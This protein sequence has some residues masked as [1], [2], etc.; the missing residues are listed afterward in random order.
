[1]DRVRKHVTF[2]N[3]ASLMALVFAMG[4]TGYAISSLPKN[5]VGT[6]QLKQGAVVSSK[7]K[8]GSLKK[9]DFKAGQLP[10]GPQGIQGPKGDQGLPGNDGRPGADGKPGT[11]GSITVQETTATADLAD[12]TKQSYD[13]VCPTGQFAL[14][15]GGRGDDV[16]SE[17]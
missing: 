17:E 9:I 14:G 16:N 4:G 13:V 3:V 10:A 15:G 1:M 2:A 6:R 12:G 8:D 5:S 11:F 7:V